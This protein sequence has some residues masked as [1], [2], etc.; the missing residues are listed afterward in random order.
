MDKIRE[1][2]AILIL[3]G[4][5]SLYSVPS[6]AQ[7]Y[8]EDIPRTFYGGVVAGANFSQVDG[9]RF[10]GYHKVGMN[11]GGIVYTQFAPNL[12]VSMEILYSQKGSRAHKAQLSTTQAYVVQSHRIRLDYAEVPIMLCYFDKRKSHF[13]LGFSYS[14]LIQNRE[15]VKTNPDFPVALLEEEFPFRKMDINF[16]IGGSLKLYQGLFLNLR[17]QYS[18]VPIRTK[19]HPELGR[20]EQFSNLYALRLMYLF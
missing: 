4:L 11:L 7:S 15:D 19:V 16:L 13:G 14:Q 6:S 5:F 12:A 3:G 9:D 1:F 17:F 2:G 18:M 10:A 20:Q 8:Y